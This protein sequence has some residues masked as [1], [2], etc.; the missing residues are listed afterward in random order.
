MPKTIKPGGEHC[1][2]WVYSKLVE[3]ESAKHFETGKRS[4]SLRL[5]TYQA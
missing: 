1:S 4:R 5:I 3:Q 2:E